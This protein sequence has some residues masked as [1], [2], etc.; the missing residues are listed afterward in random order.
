[1]NN[2]YLQFGMTSDGEWRSI[3][4]IDSGKTDLICPWCKQSLLAKKGLIRVHHFAHT[5]E[6]CRVSIGAVSQ[7][8]LPTFDTF[9]LLDTAERKY[10]E[11]RRRYGSHRNVYAFNGMDLALERLEAMKL[12]SFKYQENAALELAKLRLSKLEGL[13]LNASGQPTKA[14]LDMFN[15]LQPIA[16][17]EPHWS[18]K[19]LIEE[20]VV[21]NDYRK[22]QFSSLQTLSD[23]NNAQCF[24]FDAFW[25]RQAFVA[26]EHLEFLQ[27]KIQVLNKQSLYVMRF[28]GSFS[29]HPESFIKIGMTTREPTERLKEV[30]T[31]LKPYGNNIKGELIAMKENAGR[32]ERLIHRQLIPS[33]LPVGTFREFFAEES[34]GPLLTQLDELQI[35]PYQ[36]PSV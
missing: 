8:L 4:D 25:W 2:E 16:D 14:L 9:E 23:L 36:P 31:A 3:N 29:A 12:I 22:Y 1:M 15:A 26:P 10:M 24:W 21:S 30:I 27:N 6:T 5:G 19:Q 7:T 17:L 13:W 28:E 18:T 34:L 20:T 35:E 32:I 11:M 33:H